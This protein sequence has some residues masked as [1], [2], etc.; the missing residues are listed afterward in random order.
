MA[1]V[2]FY[3]GNEAQYNQVTHADCIYFATDTRVIILNGQRYGYNALNHKEVSSISYENSTGNLKFTY[4]NGTSDTVKLAEATAGSTS[5]TSKG[6]LMSANQVYKLSNVADNAQVNVIETVKVDNVALPVS[7]KTVN[8]DLSSIKSDIT[9]NKVVGADKSVVVT[10]GN[11]NT[12][13]SIKVNVKSGSALKLTNDGLEVDKSVLTKYVGDDKAITLSEDGENQKKFSL[14]LNSKTGNILTSTTD[15]LFASVKIKKLD[16]ASDSN[17][18]S[19]YSLVGLSSAGEEI[20]LG[21]VT[22]DIMK[23]KF[24]KNVELGKIPEGQPNAG[25]DA[26]VFTFLI[27]N[28]TEATRYVDVS[29][30]LREAEVGNG[31]EVGSDKRIKLKLNSDNENSDGTTGGDNAYLKV[32]ENGISL[33][34]LNAKLNQIKSEAVTEAGNNS[35][36]VKEKTTGFVKVNVSDTKEVTVTEENIASASDLA[37]EVQTRTQAIQSLNQQIE[38]INQKLTYLEWYEA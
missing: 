14:N 10:E 21:D 30:F 35:L 22:I 23:D 31:L 29:S 32:T 20:S 8:I 34:G 15:G 7:E 9:K 5:E 19:Q 38:T 33:T 28:G 6:G 17:I 16:T 11:E 4:S 26:L 3:R 25:N 27:E 36:K 12:P 37:S 18:A 1:T 13:T 2:K 24:L